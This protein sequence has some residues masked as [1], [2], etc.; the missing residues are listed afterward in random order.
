MF[1]QVSVFVSADGSASGCQLV[2][3]LSLYSVAILP[4]KQ[5][6]D[7]A[8]A[9]CTPWVTVWLMHGV[10]SVG[11]RFNSFSCPREIQTCIAKE[12]QPVDK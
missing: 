11:S 12:L 6:E 9:T 7:D 2:P 4:L 3:A 1:L 10:G 5:W 8:D